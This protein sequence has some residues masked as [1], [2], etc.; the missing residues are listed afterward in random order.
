VLALMQVDGALSQTA[1]WEAQ[2]S[3]PRQP[4]MVLRPGT[5]VAIQVTAPGQPDFTMDI[6]YQWL[7]IPITQVDPAAGIP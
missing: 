3:D 4:L 7:E 5:G 6:N 2:S 1:S